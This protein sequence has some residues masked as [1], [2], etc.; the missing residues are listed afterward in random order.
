[1]CSQISLLLFAVAVLVVPGHIAPLGRLRS[2]PTGQPCRRDRLGAERAQPDPLSAASAFDLMAACLRAGLPVATAAQA[3]APTA[4]APV[5]AAL[6]RAADLMA[7]GADPVAAWDQVAG[8]TAADEIR[9]VA[10]LVRRSAR[11]GAA[12]AGAISE[13]AEQFRAAVADATAA[14]A[15]RAGVLIGGPLG[16]CFLPAFLCLGIVPVVVGLGEH[17]LKG[18]LL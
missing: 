13:L 14:R 6:R 12:L 4:P 7:L 18:G 9:A 16:L 1:M 5:G 8:E 11:S 17:V 15:E 2:V 3:V 10:R